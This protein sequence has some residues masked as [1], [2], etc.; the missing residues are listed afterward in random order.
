LAN[1]GY[2]VL[3]VNYRGSTGFGKRF[4]HAADKQWGR[5]MHDD[6]VDAVKWAIA[7]G[8]ADPRRV[9]IDGGSYGGYAALAGAA[10]TPDLFRC[11]VDI[12]GVANILTWLNNI[13]PYWQIEMGI[14]KKRVGDLDDPRDREMLTRASPLFSADR[15]K[16]PM[17]IGQGA[18][19]PRVP[20]RESEQI[21]AAIEKNHGRVTYV[22]YSDEGHGFA[23]PENNLDFDAREEAFL[24]AHLGGRLEKMAGDRMPGSTAV[25]REVGASPR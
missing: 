20:Q 4:L 12:V 6:L 13:P 7:Q 8:I 3:Q 5:A 15:I 2:A 14:L 24:S 23:R 18:N 25:V 16:I 11:S 19:D 22:L 10:F 9:A 17:L 1:R 21:V